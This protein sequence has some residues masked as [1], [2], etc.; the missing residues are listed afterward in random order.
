MATL[1]KIV[2]GY[3]AYREKS[4]RGNE[5]KFRDLARRQSPQVMVIS[6]CDSRVDPAI[7]T[8]AEPGDLFTVRNVANLVPPYERDEAHHGTSAAL[9]FAVTNL[10]VGHIVVM[11]HSGCG[12]IRALVEGGGPQSADND[13]IST[14]MAIAEPARRKAVE[15]ARDDSL[16]ARAALCEHEGL[17]VSLAN[18]MTFPWIKSRVEAG[19][20]KLHAWH[21]DIGSSAIFRLD[22]ET[23]SFVPL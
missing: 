2:A 6:C 7:I 19:T 14:W 11:G 13:F 1:A 23:D 10:K 5:P 15:C 18:L 20:L 16:D 9:E 3:H 22:E 8:G 12:G 21:Y 17:K 4:Y